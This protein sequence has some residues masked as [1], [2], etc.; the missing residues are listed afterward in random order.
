MKLGTPCLIVM[1]HNFENVPANGHRI[2]ISW[3]DIDD[4]Q[5]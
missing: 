3:E 1:C 4:D 5:K 2:G